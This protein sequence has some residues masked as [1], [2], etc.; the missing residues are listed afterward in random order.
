MFHLQNHL[1]SVMWIE[2]K[3]N[4]DPFSLYSLN[5]V[6]IRQRIFI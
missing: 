2:M 1:L 6:W 5:G 4:D 3:P